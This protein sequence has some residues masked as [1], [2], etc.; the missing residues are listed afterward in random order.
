[1]FCNQAWVCDG[2]YGEQVSLC[3]R[4]LLTSDGEVIVL[5]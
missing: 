5:F 3:M 2:V 4:R 1:M